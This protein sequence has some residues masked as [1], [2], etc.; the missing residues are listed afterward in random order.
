MKN[1]PTLP[2]AVARRNRALVITFAILAVAAG[3][4]L[5]LIRFLASLL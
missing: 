4:G 1:R 3:P 2:A 5:A